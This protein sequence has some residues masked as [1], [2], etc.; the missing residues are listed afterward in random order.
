MED[1][2]QG[3]RRRKKAVIKVSCTYHNGLSRK[4]TVGRQEARQAKVK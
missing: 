1:R 3:R 2:E 4:A